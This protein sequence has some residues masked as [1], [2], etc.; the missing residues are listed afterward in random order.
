MQYNPAVITLINHQGLKILKG[1]QLQSPSPS[2]GLAYIGAYLKKNG[3]NYTA[4]D[5]C[6]LAMN[7]IRPYAKLKN[8][9]VQGL[10]NLQV[11][12]RI[13]SETKIFGFT[14]LFS[15]CWPLVLDMANAIRA[16]FPNAL[17]I[18]GGEHGTAIPEACL[19]SG[20]IDVVVMGEGEETFLELVQ[21]VSAEQ[22][23]KDIRGIAYLDDRGAFQK[24]LPRN[25]VTEIDQFPYPDWDSWPLESYIQNSQ[26]TGV[27]LGRAMPILGS[28]GCPYACSFC[29]NEG[30][31]TRR[32]LMRD[33]KALLNEMEYF[34][35]K[36]NV[37]G[38]TFMDL[39]FI[40]NR[41]KVKTFAQELISR[42]LGITY[43]IPAGTRCEAFDEELAFLLDRSGLR[44][45]AF[46]PES[47]SEEILKAIRK[48]IKLDEFIGAVKAVLKTS[49]S[50]GCY[51][52]VGFP[53]DT[54][55]TLKQS[56]H[57][58]RKLAWMG[59]HDVTVSKF[60]P[61]PGSADFAALEKEGKITTKIEDLSAVIDFFSGSNASYCRSLSSRQLYFWMLWLY[62]NFYVISFLLRP[63]RVIKNFIE[64]FT[65]Q[66]VENTRYMRFF[67]ELFVRRRKWLKS[68]PSLSPV[69]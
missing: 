13:P 19:R 4:V 51:F 52:V 11:L 69:V 61:Y 5:A 66:G 46:A 22:N 56:L 1:I 36:Y 16:Q 6:G 33:A 65:K 30:M 55:T 50:I 9:S 34:K 49:M 29:S 31:W 12:E 27:N 37:S 14:C 3:F 64:F 45:F 15:H 68:D 32:Y 53:D 8:V 7:Q 35:N 59:V 63:W 47:G 18:L 2:I 67:A 26:V 38:F 20:A 17:F 23:W 62:L 40:V 21:K 43:Q 10:T 60:T 54:R 39:T 28:R 41:N 58:I 42:N 44:N 24:N 48:Q 57:M 25:R